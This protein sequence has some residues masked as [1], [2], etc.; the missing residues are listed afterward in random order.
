MLANV[1]KEIEHKDN[2]KLRKR[3]KPAAV[4]DGGGLAPLDNVP[5]LS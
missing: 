5:Y 4:G 3:E 2:W 1:M